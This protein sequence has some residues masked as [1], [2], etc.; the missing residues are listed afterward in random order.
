MAMLNKLLAGHPVGF[1]LA[2][3]ED[4]EPGPDPG[5]RGTHCYFGPGPLAEVAAIKTWQSRPFNGESMGFMGMDRWID[6]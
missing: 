4:S 3:L 1:P 2:P 5:W 6:R